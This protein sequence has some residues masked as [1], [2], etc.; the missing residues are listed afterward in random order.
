MADCLH[1][2]LMFAVCFSLVLFI[3]SLKVVCF[4]AF[5]L[6]SNG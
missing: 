3:V 6:F 5:Q 2:D 4:Q 1:V